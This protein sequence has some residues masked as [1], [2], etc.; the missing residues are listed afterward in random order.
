M[1]SQAVLLGTPARG[2]NKHPRSNN[3]ASDS[4]SGSDP[5][6]PV[7]VFSSVQR[8]ASNHSASSPPEL[9]E[10][11]A[12]SISHTPTPA[13]IPT[14]A[15]I[16][17]QAE[18]LEKLHLLLQSASRI[19]ASDVK[20]LTA[21]QM[22]LLI[23][24]RLDSF[25]RWYPDDVYEEIVDNDDKLHLKCHD[26]PDRLFRAQY[27]N[28]NNFE[29]HL[30]GHKHIENVYHRLCAE[31]KRLKETPEVKAR[32]A[33]LKNSTVAHGLYQTLSVTI[34]DGSG[35]VNDTGSLATSSSALN[36]QARNFPYP[37][38]PVRYSRSPNPKS[39]LKPV[40]SEDDFL[41]KGEELERMREPTFSN[42]DLRASPIAAP[43]S[44]VASDALREKV[45]Y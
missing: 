15:E 30:R 29:T 36:S 6:S 1:S 17:N 35:S 33:R 31:G 32:I 2:S 20:P 4:S 34:Y 19:P 8:P 28:L 41:G 11:D 7:P 23:E 21:A 39:H 38:P 44:E 14:H 27:M 40:E 45:G 10:R 18:E 22:S 25:R 37:G 9:E 42:V 13:R 43:E 26:C 3:N 12:S 5:S 24:V 16:A